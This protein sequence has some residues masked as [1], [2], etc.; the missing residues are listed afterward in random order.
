MKA[1][2]LLLLI[3][4]ASCLTLKE[5]I[6]CFTEN[7]NLLKQVFKVIES[8]KTKDITTIFTTALSAY[9]SV[10]DEIKDCLEGEPNLQMTYCAWRCRNAYDKP[11]CIQ[12]CEKGE[13]IEV[14]PIPVN[15]TKTES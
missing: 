9:Y 2:Y 8:F 7:K 14:K 11:S 12:M 5:K 1:V 15:V 13:V 6:E 10:K 3:S 4:L